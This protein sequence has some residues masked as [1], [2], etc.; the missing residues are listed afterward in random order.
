MDR[1]R[2][3]ELLSLNRFKLVH[4]R[5]DSDIF[6]K[7]AQPEF[8][9]AKYQ[10]EDEALIFTNGYLSENS[11]LT[12]LWQLKR[13]SVEFSRLHEEDGSLPFSQRQGIS[14]MLAFRPWDFGVFS[15]LKRDR[16]EGKKSGV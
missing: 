9:N 8:L 5:A 3:I 14:L 16:V 10:R 7:Y 2:I 13:V 4:Q 11:R 12:M 15:K 6:L 1:L